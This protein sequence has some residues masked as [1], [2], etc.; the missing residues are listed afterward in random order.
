MANSQYGGNN[1]SLPATGED[2]LKIKAETAAA[3][4]VILS[5]D[6]EFVAKH[7]IQL[8]FLIIRRM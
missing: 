2:I 7:E 4:S 3:V 5:T 8:K 1:Y 6:T